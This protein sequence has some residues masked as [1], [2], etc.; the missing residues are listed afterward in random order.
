ME[1]QA[2]SSVR[3]LRRSE[4]SIIADAPRIPTVA[5]VEHSV[6]ITV[7]QHAPMALFASRLHSAPAK[8]T[9]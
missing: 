3:P 4:N 9:N 1:S 2:T 6:L 7:H 8:Q 5:L